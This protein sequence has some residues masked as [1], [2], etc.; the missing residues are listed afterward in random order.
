MGN[1]KPKTSGRSLWKKS[2][3]LHLNSTNWSLGAKHTGRKL[4]TGLW[5][6]NIL[7]GNWGRLSF[8]S[9]FIENARVPGNG[10]S[11]RIRGSTFRPS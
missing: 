4:G 7:D 1:V 5:G 9:L 10:N 6:L 2:W 3:E 11:K 8:N